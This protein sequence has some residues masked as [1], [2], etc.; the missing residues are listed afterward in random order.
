MST[1][2]GISTALS[3]L[4][5]QR[6]ALDVSGQNIANANTPG[7]TRQRADMSPVQGSSV[8][9]LWSSSPA[10]GNGVRID[11]IARLG[12]VFLD[13][14]LRSETSASSYAAAHADTLGRL[15]ATL[16]EPSDTGLSSALQTFWADWQDV[17]NAPDD[18]AAR[19]VLLGDAEALVSQVHAGYRTVQ[20]QWS[21]LRTSTA[22][23]VDQVNTTAAQIADL[24]SQIRSITVS[25]G[26]ANELMDQRSTLVTSL[27]GLV[28]A[29]ARE[30]SD[31]TMDV[32]VAG[33][34]LVRA[35]HANTISMTGSFTMAGGLTAAGQVGL[36]WDTVPPTALTLDGGTIGANI[37]DLAPAGVLGNAATT[38]DTLATQLASTV[39]AVHS[40]GS[41]IQTPPTTGV[42]FFAVDSTVPAALGLSVAITDPKDVAAAGPMPATV[43]DPSSWALD[44]SGADTI[45]ALADDPN[46]A[47]AIWHG[48]VVDL[49]VQSRSATQRSTVLETSRASAENLQLSASSVDLD[50]ESTNMLAYQRAYEGAARVMT[51]ID[52]MLD[53]LINRTGVVGR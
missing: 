40:T 12:D 41:T 22:T 10:A 38:W 51:A 43:T 6:Q 36:Q 13:T 17:G 14:R 42:D 3:S 32:M 26:N 4:I 33:N 47:D 27:S 8:P 48:F 52:Q 37:D 23:L 11:Q 39:N 35:D 28:G 53:T 16:N 5:A 45:S 46:G 24:N 20:T 21:Q 31:G 1:F 29:T 50:E 7:Y 2:S 34:A 19:K 30:R 9:S 25:G 15:E 18:T 44:G 49:G